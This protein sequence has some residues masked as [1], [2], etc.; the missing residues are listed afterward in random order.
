M[1]HI[2]EKPQMAPVRLTSGCFDFVVVFLCKILNV[3]VHITGT[4]QGFGKSCPY[5][6]LAKHPDAAKRVIGKFHFR[7][8]IFRNSFLF[9]SEYHK[10]VIHMF[11]GAR[12]G[13][14]FIVIRPLVPYIDLHHP[15]N[16]FIPS[17]LPSDR[18][19]PI[20]L[21]LTSPHQP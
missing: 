13:K 8:C 7:D 15:W 10:P 11:W 19:T 21:E 3:H 12:H 16:P 20:T 1:N 17:C 6:H 4:D 9:T 5:D 2:A 14:F 18:T